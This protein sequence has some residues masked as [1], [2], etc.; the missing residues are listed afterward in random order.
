MYTN[1]AAG[2]LIVLGAVIAVLGFLLAGEMVMVVIGLGSIAA[3]GILG[4]LDRR[5]S[6]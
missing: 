3:G 6:R 4:I 5:L 1:L 2:L